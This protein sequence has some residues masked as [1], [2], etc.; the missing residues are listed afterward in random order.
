MQV[1]L[2]AKLS[3]LLEGDEVPKTMQEA[4]IAK[5]KKVTGLV[6]SLRNLSGVD[7]LDIVPALRVSRKYANQNQ[8]RKF[9]GRGKRKISAYGVETYSIPLEISE[10]ED[11][12]SL[13]RALIPAVSCTNCSS[14][15]TDK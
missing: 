13:L 3:V 1:R 15:R 4:L 9:L 12:N 14:V 2:E 7:A 10:A 8:A 6:L 11:R 5:N